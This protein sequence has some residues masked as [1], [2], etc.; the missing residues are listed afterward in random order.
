MLDV[1]TIDAETLQDYE[2]LFISA[3]QELYPQYEW[4]YG[5]LLY[6]TVIRP[7]AV[8]AANDEDDI[9]TLRK[10]MSLY[11]VSI[12]DVPDQDL[13]NSLASNFRVDPKEGIYGTGE[14]AVYS[15]QQNNVYIPVASV[16]S[17]GGVSLT[18]D[19]VYV[20]VA[21]ADD[22]VDKDDTVYR[23]L[24]QVGSEWAFSV[25]VRTSDFTDETVAKGLAV[26]MEGRPAQV[27]RIE[28]SSSVVGGRAEASTEAILEQAQNGITAK[29]PSG[30]AHLR[31]L[32]ADQSGVNVLS[33]VS[34]G[35]NDPECIRDRDNVFGI[36]TGGRVDAYCRNVD[37]PATR[38]ITVQA[39][40]ES[41]TGAWSMFI[42]KDAGL[43]FYRILSIKHPDSSVEV[44]DEDGLSVEY[45]YSEVTGGPHVFSADTA[46]YSI[47]QTA[48]VSFDY[49]VAETET[50][51]EVELLAMPSLETLQE[52][53]NQESIR[54]EAQ[55]VLVRAPHPASVSVTVTVERVPGDTGT[56]E[57]DLQNAIAAAINSTEIG[58]DGLDA[59]LVVNAVEAVDQELHVV[60]PVVLQ[61]DFQLP[62]SSILSI[63]S[64]QGRITVPESDYAWVTERNTFYY[65]VASNV[66][67]ELRDRT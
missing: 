35:I 36:S 46:R 61:A 53:V 43:G 27:S 52:F 15:R 7:T 48:Y 38:T 54:N 37:I 65:C 66:A 33:Q 56:T 17:A 34:F 45:G 22:Y 6:E 55:D 14:M 16:L 64:L 5:S 12:A 13:L 30:N 21:N 1:D 32:F 40:R 63:T 10:N 25:P 3:Y 62:D 41:L 49:D 8:R 39:T 57:E 23:Q 19:K 42:D 44:T 26:T 20:G 28:I 29:I 24:V 60:F 50:S 47:Y 51:F 67:V 11:L 9:D 18:T 59:S 31:A 4:S 2:E 58:V